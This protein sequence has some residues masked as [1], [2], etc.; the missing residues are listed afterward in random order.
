[1][2]LTNHF[3]L[4]AKNRGYNQ[5]LV[6]KVA[7][8]YILV[9]EPVSHWRN[10]SE[11]DAC[12]QK[13]KQVSGMLTQEARKQRINLQI[14]DFVL[15]SSS[16]EVVS[17]ETPYGWHTRVVQIIHRS[18]LQELQNEIKKSQGFAEVAVIFLFNRGERSF[19]RQVVD[20]VF[21]DE[22]AAAYNT[23]SVN[24][25]AH[26]ILHLF[27]AV[28]F[29]YMERVQKAAEKHLRGGLMM[30]NTEK[31]I[32]DDF[33][34]YL[35]GWHQ[36]LSRRAASFLREIQTVTRTEWENG[37]K[38]KIQGGN[39]RM[40]FRNG[41]IYEGTFTHGQP[42]GYGT[43]YF[44]DGGRYIGDVRYGK[45][46][47]QGKIL[48][49]NGDRYEGSVKDSKLE[50]SGVLSRKNGDYYVGEFLEN[51]YNGYGEYHY[52]SGKIEKGYWKKGRLIE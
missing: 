42:N 12:V 19:A 5:R 41:D 16:N 2:E 32:V 46:Y 13:I 31:I 37:L 7:F 9:S 36:K 26:E 1:M 14:K 50:G 48:Y 29:Y 47:G 4:Q 45:L 23:A 40:V 25:I 38:T 51:A 8:V 49:A 21:E 27:G 30:G 22:F 39:D 3:F 15:K 24:D 35:I 43:Y 52:A 18:S 11:V 44:K 20:N 17:L 10:Q 28:D 6:G 34:L 33:T